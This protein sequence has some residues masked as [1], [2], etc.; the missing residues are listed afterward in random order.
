MPRCG[1]END[2]NGFKFIIK[3]NSITSDTANVTSNVTS[4]EDLNL[5]EKTILA[6]LKAKPDASREELAEK[7]SK[8]VR[9]VQRTLNSLRAKGYIER[10]GAKQNTV[11]KVKK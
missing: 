2:Q 4:T 8:T 10:E 6:I 3:R 9:T 11:W 7:A 1:Y 5:T